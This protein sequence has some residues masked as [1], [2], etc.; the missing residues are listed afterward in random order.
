MQAHSVRIQ[1]GVS[2]NGVLSMVSVSLQMNKY[3]AI[4][5][6]YHRVRACDWVLVL[7]LVCVCVCEFVGKSNRYLN[8]YYSGFTSYSPY[9]P[10]RK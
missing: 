6:T 4:V 10:M 2:H 8:M 1:M 7:V 5:T 3:C 9:G